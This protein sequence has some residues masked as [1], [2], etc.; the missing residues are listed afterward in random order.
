MKPT[1]GPDPHNPDAEHGIIRCYVC[2]MDL[3]DKTKSNEKK[4][5]KDKTG[6]KPGLVELRCDGTGFAGGGKALVE[7]EGVSFQC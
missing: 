6:V 2:D 7:K 5:K 3:S 1:E 4:G